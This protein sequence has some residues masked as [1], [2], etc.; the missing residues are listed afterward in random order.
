MSLSND[1]PVFFQNNNYNNILGL[2]D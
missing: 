1:A 2:N